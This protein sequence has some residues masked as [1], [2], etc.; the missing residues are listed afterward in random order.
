MESEKTFVLGV[1]GGSSSGK[2]YMTKDI[3]SMLIDLGI[4]CTVV[5]IDDYYVPARVRKV[6]QESEK[7][8]SFDHIS[9]F[10]V[11]VL[12][13]DLQELLAGNTV[14]GVQYD[15]EKSDRKAEKKEL[16]PANVIILEGIMLLSITDLY[17]V[18]TYSVFLDI[19]LDWMLHSRIARDTK[20]VEQG[21]RGRTIE[22][23]LAQ[24]PQVREGHLRLLQTVQEVKSR[25]LTP[26]TVI[27]NRYYENQTETPALDLVR[28]FVLRNLE[29]QKKK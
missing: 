17:K 15:M 20:T 21:G 14:Q 29:A 10:D 1:C 23:V 12:L 6:L 2:S 24:W 25:Q 3:S 26:V 27:E 16:L 18:L 22:S 5:P 19:E 7:W 28:G 4:S 9:A 8:V 13:A 11:P